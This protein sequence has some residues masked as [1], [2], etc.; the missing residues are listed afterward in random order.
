M[1][2]PHLRQVVVAS[3]ILD[4]SVVE[5]ALLDDLLLLA[6]TL[7]LRKHSLLDFPLW[8]TFVHGK[9]EVG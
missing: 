4:N 9:D 3:S 2:P 6:C 5:S 7:H 8:R 1:G